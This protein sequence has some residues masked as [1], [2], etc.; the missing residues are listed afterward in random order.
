MTQYDKA[1]DDFYISLR[2]VWIPTKEEAAELQEP[3]FS[4]GERWLFYVK[5]RGPEVRILLNKKSD[6]PNPFQA[7]VPFF[8]DT[9]VEQ[10]RNSEG[11]LRRTA[12]LYPDTRG[13]YREEL[14]AGKH[15]ELDLDYLARPIDAFE[16]K[17]K[18]SIP[19]GSY[20]TRTVEGRQVRD[21]ILPLDLGFEVKVGD[22]VGVAESLNDAVKLADWY[23]DI[24]E[25][26]F[27][28]DWEITKK[29]RKR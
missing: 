16:V 17:R 1:P 13:V 21:H 2:G 24:Q 28:D 8:V 26:L 15:D 18:I 11:K 9:Y 5:D 4:G 23:T 25:D 20:L 10:R 3:S 7:E 6:G 19:H 22:R 29:R 14:A 12:R 27:F